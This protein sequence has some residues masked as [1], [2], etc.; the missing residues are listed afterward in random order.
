[1]G[2]DEVPAQGTGGRGAPGDRLR[3]VVDLPAPGP[4]ADGAPVLEERAVQVDDV[5]GAAPFVEVV[6]V[7]RGHPHVR[8]VEAGPVGDGAV[9]RVGLR[10]PAHRAA[11]QVPGPH[12]LG[13]AR[14]GVQGGE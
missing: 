11:P 2:A 7:L 14:P 10:V 3:R 4:G 13:V 8:A 9:P 1:A 5:A 6:D 12:R